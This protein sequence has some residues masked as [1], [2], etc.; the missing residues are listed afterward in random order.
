MEP[1]NVYYYPRVGDYVTNSRGTVY[2]VEKINRVNTVCRDEQGKLWNVRG[3]LNKYDGDPGWA[4]APKLRPGTVVNV[5]RE[6]GMFTRQW[7]RQFDEFTLFVV[8]DADSVK[9][10]FVPLGGEGMPETTRGYNCSPDALK[11]V[12]TKGM[13]K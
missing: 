11:V 1:I 9:A 2:R 3:D 5:K 6:S 4:A 13:F 12:D 8:T 10:K 7:F